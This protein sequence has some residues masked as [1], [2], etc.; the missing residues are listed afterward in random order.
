MLWQVTA[1]RFCAGLVTTG[2]RVTDAAPILR[3][4]CMGQSRDRVR[5]LAASLGW[6]IR[7][8]G[9]WP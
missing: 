5:A 1:R 4:Q 8:V 7:F 6:S 9:R 2:E 3:R